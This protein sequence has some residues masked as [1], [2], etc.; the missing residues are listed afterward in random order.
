MPSSGEKAE[1]EELEEKKREEEEDE[2]AGDET[3][4]ELERVVGEHGGDA[5]GCLG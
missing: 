4:D 1:E 5:L 3:F 2:L